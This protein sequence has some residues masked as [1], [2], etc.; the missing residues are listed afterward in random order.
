[1]LSEVDMSKEEKHRQIKEY[2]WEVWQDSD[3]YGDFIIDLNKYDVEGAKEIGIRRYENNRAANVN[4]PKL[5]NKESTDYSRDILGACG[6]LAAIKWLIDNGYEASFDK[7]SNVDNITSDTDT[8]D[9][10]IVFEGKTFSV[11]V[12]TT[13]KPINS[14]LIYPLHKGKKKRQPD[15]FVLVCQIDQNR[16]VIKGFTTADKIL[17]NIDTD[18]PTKAYS[19]HEKDLSDDLEK[20]VKELLNNKGNNNE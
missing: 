19:I 13:E 7:F 20:V 16:H 10:D 6:E 11:E 1:M 15:V 18:L 5:S 4:N 2:L 12:K 9:T 17:N 8:F 14:K 3:R